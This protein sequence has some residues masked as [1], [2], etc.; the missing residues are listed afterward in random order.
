M[1]RI[2][3]L[4]SIRFVLAF[5]VLL[6]HG[7]VPIFSISLVARYPFLEY[8]NALIGNSFVGIAAVMAFFIISGFCIHYP[9]ACGK[10]MNTK[11]FYLKRITR[12]AIPAIAAW[13]IYE[14][15]LNLYMGVIWSLICE[16]IYYFIYPLLL[17]VGAKKFKYLLWISFLASLTISVVY[18]TNSSIYNGDFHRMG[19][20][21][22]WLVSLPVW[23][24]GLILAEDLV[25]SESITIHLNYLIIMR[26]VVW[27]GAAI[28]SVLRF[29]LHIA[30]VF[31]LP[32]YSLLLY[33]WLKIEIRYFSTKEESKILAW[34][35]LMSYSLYLIHAYVIEIIRI[36]YSL[37]V[38]SLWLCLLGIVASLFFGCLFYLLV[39]KP[40]HYLSK[41]LNLKD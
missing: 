12:I 2:T 16:L 6:G 38:L 13:C 11:E 22:T 36:S 14:V 37:Q 28:C 24:L 5:I 9:Y 29:H 27:G 17:K 3:G 33:S 41:S 10:K 25:Q 4:D 20:A 1:K 31:T 19:F 30:Y 34:G 39:E 18:S 26:L 21:F 40:S 8:V 15:T 7:T 32:I 23:I 35:G